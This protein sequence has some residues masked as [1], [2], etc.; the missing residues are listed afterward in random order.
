MIDLPAAFAR[1]PP[2]RARYRPLVLALTEGF[3][4]HVTLGGAGCAWPGRR[5][6][7]GRA[8]DVMEGFTRIAPLWAAW[9]AGGGDDPGFS[10]RVAAGLAAGPQH[11]GAV[12]DRDQRLCEAADVAI[13][14]WLARG[15]LPA[16]T[17]ERVLDWLAQ[18]AGRAHADNNWHLFPATVLAVLAAMGR[19]GDPTLLSAKL[20][21]VRAFLRADGLFHDGP[22]G[23]VDWYSAWGFHY[24]LGW[25]AAI[26]GAPGWVA[27]A[28][29]AAVPIVHHLLT[30]HGPLLFGRSL[31]YR[32]A[33][34]A[35]LTV[36]A[37]LGDDPLP[38]G[39]AR[40]ALDTTFAH[41]LA[42]GLV[43][44]GRVTQGPLGDDPRWLDSYAGPASPLWSLRAL[45]PAL[46]L[47][48]AHPFW[49]APPSPLP[50]ERGSFTLPLGGCRIEGDGATGHV[51]LV[52]PEG[53]ARPR[54]QR[55]ALTARLRDMVRGYV[56]RPANTALRYD[57]PRYSTAQPFY[58]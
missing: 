49:T 34:P 1:T 2:G 48:Q 7:N 28:R 53:R 38:A 20:E 10:H 9:L 18:A 17:A 40:H 26:G 31:H 21:R 46:T 13:T 29:A 37:M 56:S 55:H 3:D 32:A 45:I 23:R 36:A 4:A 57:L 47:P 51:T 8:A 54:F 25:I 24:Q 19:P 6:G 16:V 27:E 41:H 33:A 35:P 15:W 39:A 22:A 43:R 5:S 52:R 14:L 44:D 50:V 11:W 12:G 42:H 30:P 58:Q